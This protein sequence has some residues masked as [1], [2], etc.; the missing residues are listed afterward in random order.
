MCLSNLSV[1]LKLNVVL[2][3]RLLCLQPF[4][5]SH[6]HFVTTV[7][8]VTSQVL[9][10]CPELQCILFCSEEGNLLSAKCLISNTLE[11]LNLCQGGRNASICLGIMLKNND[12]YICV[13]VCAVNELYLMLLSFHLIF[14][15]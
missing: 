14:V 2:E 6:F 13:C 11:F 7:E 8:L 5:N 3:N 1:S 15:T 10:H 9:L 12:I 4:T